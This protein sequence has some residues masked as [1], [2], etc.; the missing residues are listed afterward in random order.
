MKSCVV[1]IKECVDHVKV[2]CGDGS[3][4][5]VCN[6]PNIFDFLVLTVAVTAQ[7]VER[8]TAEREVAALISEAGSI[9]RILKELR[10]EGTSFVLPTLDLRVARMTT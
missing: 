6:L 3:E 9:L 10:I 4:Y 5:K 8:L 2:I 7:S 1:G